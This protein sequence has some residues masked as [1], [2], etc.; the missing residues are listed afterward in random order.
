MLERGRF[1][2]EPRP[3]QAEEETEVVLKHEQSDELEARGR[4]VRVRGRN[5]ILCRVRG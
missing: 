2:W 4:R 5:A 3:D 1:V